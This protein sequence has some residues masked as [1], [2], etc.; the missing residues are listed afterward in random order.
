V[1]NPN[2]AGKADLI[3]NNIK[4]SFKKAFVDNN[5]DGQADDN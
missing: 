1:L 5:K 3:D 2:D 4:N